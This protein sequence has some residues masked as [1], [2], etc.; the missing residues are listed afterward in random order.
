[1][2]QETNAR[3][4]EELKKDILERAKLNGSCI[5]EY[6]S[7]ANANNLTTLMRVVKRNFVWCC[8]RD[9]ITGSM[10]NKYQDMFNDSEIFYNQDVKYGYLLLDEGEKTACGNTY[11]FATNKSTI[12]A[13]CHAMIIADK[14]AHVI[15]HNDTFVTMLDTSTGRFYGRARVEVFGNTEIELND[16]STAYVYSNPKSIAGHD[17]SVIY[18]QDIG[19][20]PAINCKLSDNAIV[21]N[22]K[23]QTRHYINETINLKK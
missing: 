23:L 13:D 9:I 4:F 22:T 1:M 11:V 14:S 20:L 5:I 8:Q 3:I 7:A 12:N 21:I 10:I 18:I 2:E 6:R 17:Y 15:A 19:G 16:S